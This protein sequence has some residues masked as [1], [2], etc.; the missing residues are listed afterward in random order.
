MTA[1]EMAF[2]FCSNF[3]AEAGCVLAAESL[4]NCRLLTM[5]AR[6][7]RPPL[8]EAELTGLINGLVGVQHVELFGGC[9]L[10]RLADCTLGGCSIHIHRFANCFS[11]LADQRQ[12]DGWLASGAYLTTPGWLSNWPE[13]LERLG[14][15]QKTARELFGES[16]N[17]IVLLDTGTDSRS[18][19]R[20]GDF[21]SYVGLTSDV[22]T[23]G[24]DILK[25]LITKIHLT[26]Q[27]EVRFQRLTTEYG[28]LQ[29]QATM[30]AMAID[31]LTNLARIVDEEQ[32][33]EGMMDVYA[34][35]FAPK[36]INYLEFERGLPDR[37]WMHIPEQSDH[38]SALKPTAV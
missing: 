35:L 2:V 23:M 17:R 28:V 34:M 22:A 38:D 15:D 1:T 21:S 4:D 19:E 5:P 10:A 13:N 12:I 3:M 29:K 14:L 24:L 25:L 32:A 31:L 9:C 18:A 30:H 16:I 11:M 36:K 27:C 26:R 37:L 20:F 6:C 8:D 7:G 33:V